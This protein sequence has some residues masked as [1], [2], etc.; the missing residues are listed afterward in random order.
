MAS[1]RI[2]LIL[3]IAAPL[4]F[5][6]VYFLIDPAK[7]AWMPRCMFHTLTGLD[8]PG[9]G[10]Q[11]MIHALLH[12]DITAAWHHNAFLLC[13]LPWLILL[14]LSDTGIVKNQRLRKG[15]HSPLAVGLICVAIVLWTFLRNSLFS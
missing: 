15:L 3:W 10:S 6:A 12:G 11:R 9:C 14:G 1:R 7:S 4:L 5:M 2:K 8:C 13:F